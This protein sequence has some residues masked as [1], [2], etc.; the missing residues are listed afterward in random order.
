MREEK[1]NKKERNLKKSFLRLF[2]VVLIIFW[3]IFVYGLSHQTGTESSGLSRKIAGIFFKSEEMID[4]FEPIIRKLAHF[5]EY[6]LGGFLFYSLFS[7]YTYTI[8]QKSIISLALGIWYAS[9]DEIH[10]LFIPGRS[11]N[12]IDVGIDSLGVLFGILF[13]IVFYKIIQNINIKLK[14]RQEERKS[15]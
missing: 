2:L 10:Q 3:T 13:S 7:T 5:S 6:V 14:E 15:E 11:G 1:G 9:L 8:K 4:T 12:V